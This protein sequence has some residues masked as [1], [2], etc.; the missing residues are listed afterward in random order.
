MNNLKNQ[1]GTAL[2]ATLMFLMAMGVLSTALI[3]TV[4]NE[5]RTSTSYK[6]NQ[7][8]FYVADGGVQ[9]AVRW[10]NTVYATHLPSTDFDLTSSP[11]RFAGSDVILA[12]QAGFTTNYPQTAAQDA[13][14]ISGFSSAF[15][16]TSLQADAHNSGIYA[17]NAT[18][19]KHS[20]GT[21]INLTNFANYTSAV[22]RWQ[23]NGIGYWGSVAKPM[24][25]THITAIIENS[26]TSIFDCGLC[27][28]DSLKITGGLTVNSYDPSI[29]P[30]NATTNSGNDGDVGTN[31][32]I[33]ADGTVTIDGQ[34]AYGPTGTL[35]VGANVDVSGGIT[36]LPEPKIFPPV[37][38]FS[39][40]TVNKTINSSQD[41]TN[42]VTIRLS[43]GNPGSGMFGDI[44][45][46]GTLILE[47]GT[48][49]INSISEGAQGK[50]RLT[51]D[52]T[53][54]VKS[55]FDVTG[56][57]VLNSGTDP[58]IPPR[59]TVF[60]YPND[61]TRLVQNTAKLA[62]GSDVNINF[63]GP[64]APLQISGGSN[65]SGSFIAQGIEAGG[66]GTIH[67]NIGNKDTNF[68]QRPYRIVSWS[69]DS[70]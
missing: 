21:F 10:F 55:G 61:P 9:N 59:L 36:Q 69:Q 15:H 17:L 22:E 70:M 32:W 65:L 56:Q 27:G 67:N 50:I 37:P 45:V 34:M 16:N 57:G 38:S 24:G 66:G 12:G 6:A 68:V 54:Y 26:G 20:E 4:N 47:P 29:G 23:L 19:L 2:I 30:W 41:D 33:Y 11:V 58:L 44:T 7:Q 51:G 1:Q 48:Y 64:G 39:V 35:T 46:R 60:Y 42:P 52:T 8:A 43:D 53:L 25:I 14:T 18:L 31:G 13:G 28:K 3:F 5:M 49:Y 40:G 62:G 63:Y